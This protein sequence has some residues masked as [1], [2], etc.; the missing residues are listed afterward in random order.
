MSIPSGNNSSCDESKAVYR[1]HVFYSDQN[2]NRVYDSLP[3][4][5]CKENK[6]ELRL[7][8]KIK[9]CMDD[10]KDNRKE[11]ESLIYEFRNKHCFTKEVDK[12]TQKLIDYLK[13]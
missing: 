11:C 5:E 6:K 13:K 7:L 2:Y 3:I 9:K 10:N 4:N 8:E 1:M 12:E